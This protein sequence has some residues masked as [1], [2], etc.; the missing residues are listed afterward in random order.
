MKATTN[1][2]FSFIVEKEIKVGYS[3]SLLKNRPDVISA[4]YGLI[5]AFELT[6]ATTHK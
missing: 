3:A 2:V 1:N 4:E 6:N 5:N